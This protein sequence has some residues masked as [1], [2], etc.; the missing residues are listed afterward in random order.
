MATGYPGYNSVIPRE[1][2]AIGEILRQRGYD[3]SWYGGARGLE[4][5]PSRPAGWRPISR[6]RRTNRLGE[7]PLAM[8][9]SS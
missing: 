7:T 8:A 6:R 9:F 3:T 5:E 4:G 1:A 2:V